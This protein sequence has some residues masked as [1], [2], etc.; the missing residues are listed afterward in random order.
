MLYAVIT[1]SKCLS[2]VTSKIIHQLSQTLTCSTKKECIEKQEEA[3]LTISC[4]SARD[5]DSSFCFV[6]INNN[7][8]I[9]R[10]NAY[11]FCKVWLGY[12]QKS[13]TFLVNVITLKLIC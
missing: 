13:A 3:T 1:N 7:N 9:T 11:R 2:Y 12:F 8:I 6:M 4:T 5:W 10:K